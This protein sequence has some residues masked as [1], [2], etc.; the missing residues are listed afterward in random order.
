MTNRVSTKRA[1]ALSL[2]SMLLCVSMLIGSTYAWFTDT[3]TTA[4]NKIQAGTLDVALEM[5]TDN[6]ATWKNAEGETLNFMTDDNRKDI[7]WEPGCTYALPLLRVVNNGNLAL[8]YKIMITGIKGSAKLNVVIEWTISDADLKAEHHLAEKSASDALTITGHMKDDAGNEYQGLSIDG[9]SIT[10]YATQDT[11]EKDS[12]GS[13]YDQDA[14]YNPAIIEDSEAAE[15]ELSKNEENIYVTLAGD[16]TFDVKPYDQKPMGGDK[17]KQI[18]I[19]GKGY[20]LTFNNTNSDW[21]NVTWGD[22]K[23]VI[24]NAV[25]DN[26]GYNAD[27]GA[28]NSHDIYF[29]GNVEFENVVFTNAVAIAGTATLKNVT[30]SDKN[31][32][33]DTYMLWICAGSHVSLENVTIDGTSAVGK[34]NRAITV[35]DQYIGNPEETTL[36]VNGLTATSDKYAA[37]YVTSKSATTVNLNGVIDVTGTAAND[38][39]VQESSDS[40]GIVTVN[41][42]STKVVK[43]DSQEDVVNAI[44]AGNGTIE[45]APNGTFTLDNGIANEG[46]KSRNITFVGDGTITV[47]V[48]T[49]AVSAEGGKLNYQRGST[50]TFENLMIQGGEGSFDGI[51]CDELVY[52]NCT[53]KGKLTLYGKATFIN[54]VFENDMANQYSIWTWGGTDVT[55][56]GCTFNTNGKAILL[57]G[58]A[59]EAKPTN[60][61]VKNCTF[62]DRKNGAAGKAAIEIGNDYNATYTLTVENATVNGFADGKNTG[63]KLWANKNSMDAAHL[64]V[65]IDGTKV[66]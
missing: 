24:K 15:S 63:S 52:K 64:T 9:I 50:F 66:Q 59:T 8:K 10:V 55:F 62:N 14:E 46:D 45:L 51:V 32:T 53:I 25:I 43:A 60:L 58:Q 54:C 21:N 49:N 1:L 5:S 26:S 6:G 36:T 12:N 2:L 27:G 11:V 56:E 17:T 57:Y 13:D 37:I 42:N 4:V 39:F 41:D 48:V 23:L 61:V 19:D 33:Q 29:N 20:K 7:L 35:K 44:A 38:K 28:W 47:D 40:T 34:A 16:V 22:A 18:V 65:T 3:A 31:A 30:I